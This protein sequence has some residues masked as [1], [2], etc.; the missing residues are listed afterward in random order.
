MCSRALLG[1]FIGFW[2]GTSYFVG[3]EGFEEGPEVFVF[4]EGL[5]GVVGGGVG[6]GFAG[7]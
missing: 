4:F 1:L 6:H 3:R 7:V 5:E 2:F